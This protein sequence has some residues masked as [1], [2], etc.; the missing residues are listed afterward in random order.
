MRGFPHTTARI[1]NV[2]GVCARQKYEP[3]MRATLGDLDSPL[4]FIILL[5]NPVIDHTTINIPTTDTTPIAV[6]DDN[7]DQAGRIAALKKKN[8]MKQASS[9]PSPLTTTTTSPKPFHQHIITKS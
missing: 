8:W 7:N 5:L 9:N 2:P 3:K 4:H 1:E 6:D